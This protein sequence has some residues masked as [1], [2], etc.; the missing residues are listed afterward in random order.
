MVRVALSVALVAS[1]GALVPPAPPRSRPAS[2]SL[3]RRG[4][5]QRRKNKASEENWSARLGLPFSEWSETATSAQPRGRRPEEERRKGFLAPGPSSSPRGDDDDVVD[6]PG[7]P[8]DGRTMQAGLAVVLLLVA[9][10]LSNQFTDEWSA[11]QSAFRF[12]SSLDLA[13]TL[14]DVSR[15]VEEM[16]PSGVLYFAGVYVLAEVLALPAVPLT[17]SAGYLFGAVQ[18]TAVVLVAATIAAGISFLIGRFL[19]RGWVED[20]AADSEQFQAI[21]AAVKREG[22]K[23]VLLLRLSPIFPFALSNYIYGLTAVEFGPYLAATLLGFAPGTALYVYGGEVASV[24]QQ[25]AAAAGDA[26]AGAGGAPFP[27]Y[28]Y[29]GFLGAGIALAAKVTDIA[30]EALKEAGADFQNDK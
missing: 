13:A 18:G 14:S 19:L 15:R 30:S 28:A 23:I 9:G 27:W 6:S 25:S 26:V 11:V 1:V 17:A 3:S 5:A 24:V 4:D 10:C 20:I 16:G 2:T 21:D 12:V 22:F 7:G 29:A 8:L